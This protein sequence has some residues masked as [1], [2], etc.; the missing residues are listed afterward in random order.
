MKRKRWRETWEVESLHGRL[1]ERGWGGAEGRQ[2]WSPQ[3]VT[4]LAGVSLT[5]VRY[6]GAETGVHGKT[7]LR[8]GKASVRFLGNI[9]VCAAT[10]H[11]IV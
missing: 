10:L 7:V 4:L 8:L 11:I 1:C 5:G 3:E 9:Q 2:G 6:T